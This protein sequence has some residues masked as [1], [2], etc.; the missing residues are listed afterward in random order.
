MPKGNPI[1]KTMEQFR[2][3]PDDSALLERLAAIAGKSKSEFVRSLIRA[4]GQELLE[5]QSNSN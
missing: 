4:V 3:T 5:V 2:M 1:Y